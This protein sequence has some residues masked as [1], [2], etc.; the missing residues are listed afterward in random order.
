MTG[1]VWLRITPAGTHMNRLFFPTLLR[2]LLVALILGTGAGAAVLWL[3][4]PGSVGRAMP[5]P[6]AESDREVAWLDP[7][8]ST[9]W[10]RFVKAA[11]WLQE[12]QSSDF[13]LDV[14]DR[15]AFP[16]QTT[17]VPELVLSQPGMPGSLRVRWYKLLSTAKTEHWVPA[18][19][20][21]RRPPLAIIGGGTT[22]R[23]KNLV[24]H[25]QA[26]AEKGGD[27]LPLLLLTTA[28]ADEDEPGKPLSN[29]Y[30]GRTYRFCFTNRQMATVVTDFINSQDDLRPDPGPLYL[31]VWDDDS[32]SRD[33][34][35]RFIQ[36]QGASSNAANLPV[37]AHIDYTV[38]SFNEPNPREAEAAKQLLE[39]LARHP[40]QRR[41]LLVMPAGSSPARRLLRELEQTAPLDSH[42]FVVA[43]G[44]SISFTNIYRD[45]EVTWPIR[46][47]PFPLVLFCHCN[48]VL[49]AA[50]ASAGE[51][52]LDPNE[53]SPAT[54]TED[55][56]LFGNIV[57]ALVQAACQD[58]QFPSSGD[59]LGVR[60]QQVHW[61]DGQVRL[62]GDGPLLFN[63]EG[64]ERGNRR[65]G[66]GEHVVCLRPSFTADGRVLAQA[67]LAVWAWQPDR[68]PGS[69][70]E[71]NPREPLQVEYE[72]PFRGIEVKRAQA[73]P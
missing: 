19:L 72:Q 2:L 36:A 64:A 41:P 34:G 4:P 46:D 13:A 60:L 18:L 55:L 48:P 39:E 43:T 62:G 53:G 56:L 49:A 21:G 73:A 44:D 69:R 22:N 7:A 23:A 70:W 29:V 37:C 25:L 57:Q 14:D 58:H 42:K 32:Y 15:K 38:G 11:K 3:L 16:T 33:L 28:T 20:A 1:G 6:L 66:T 45:R 8:T 12:Q 9:D 31:T 26:A 27:N 40:G 24:H 54:G 47:L 35:E 51:T 65:S 50:G 52:A 10:A 17:E 30:T 67:A 71:P 61:H 5:L 63:T 68:P 59:E